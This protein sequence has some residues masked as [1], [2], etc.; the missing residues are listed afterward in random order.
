[1]KTIVGIATAAFFLISTT[2][3]S[4][5]GILQEAE[6]SVCFTYHVSGPPL[7]RYTFQKCKAG[8][9]YCTPTHAPC[10]DG[11]PVTVAP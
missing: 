7:T 9:D 11:V 6:V 5:A 4:S 2:I 3:P 1:M 8:F 10:E